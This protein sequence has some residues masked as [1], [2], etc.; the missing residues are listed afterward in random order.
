VTVDG[1]ATGGAGVGRL[2]DGRV[3]FVDGALPGEQVSVV[4]T[5]MRDRFARARTS[6][7]LGADPERVQPLCPS[8]D[9]G[10]GGCDMQHASHDRQRHLKRRIVVESIERLGKVADPPVSIGAPLAA[11]RYRTSLRCMVSDG[12]VAL[13]R[14]RSHDPIVIDGCMVADPLLEELL[15]EGHFGSAREVTLRVGA[16]TGE[17]M[18]IVSPKV[19]DVRLPDDVL[20]VGADELRRG[21]RAW[22]HERVADHLFRISARSFFQTRPDGADRLVTEVSAALGPS[23]GAL[24]DLYGGVGLFAATAG[25][26]HSVTVVE[27]NRSSVADARVNLADREARVIRSRVEDWKPAAADVVVAD[28]SRSGLGAIGAAQIAATG[29]RRAVLVSCDPASLGR[30]VGL[31]HDD[32]Y[33]LVGSTLVDLFPQTSHIE[34]VSSFDRR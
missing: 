10:C 13:R 6:A 28:P 27:Q 8:V 11:W 18:A 19:R 2:E 31:L 23:G 34:V 32:G 7:I 21:R 25:S 12:V 4:I 24:V 15:T 14:R 3:V 9:A 22:V 5:E 17:R 29:A 16:R 1:I 26:K 20:V 33:D 30:D